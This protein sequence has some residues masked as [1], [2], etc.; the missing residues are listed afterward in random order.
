[1]TA[2][3]R[4]RNQKR[5]R[6]YGERNRD[7]KPVGAGQREIEADPREQ[8]LDDPESLPVSSSPLP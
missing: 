5:T 2:T 6:I 3:Y 8:R 4:G 1:L 7:E